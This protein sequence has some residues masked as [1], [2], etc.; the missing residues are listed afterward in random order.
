M[1]E[2][3]KHAL[4]A[5]FLA[6]NN[7]GHEA[8]GQSMQEPMHTIVTSDQKALV[9]SQLVKLR[10]HSIGQDVREPIDTISAQGTHFGEVRAFLIKYYGTDQNPQLREPLGTVT[11][12]DRFGLVTVHGEEYQIVDIGMRMLAPHELYA[13]QGFPG[14]YIIDHGIDETG[15][16]IPLTKTSQVRMCGNSVCP[17]V[18]EALVRANFQL[19]LQREAEVA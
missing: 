2:G 12:K 7:G 4:V 5:A 18:A 15:A 6:K 1:A 10:H 9:T 3:N 19:E 11:T 8:T 17:P 14:D 13:A 16:T